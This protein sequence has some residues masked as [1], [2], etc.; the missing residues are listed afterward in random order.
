MTAPARRTVI[1]VTSH[2]PFV[3]RFGPFVAS[4][5]RRSR[6][7]AINCPVMNKQA[8]FTLPELIVTIVVLAILASLAAPAFKNFIANERIVA[9]ANELISSF[10]LARTEALKRNMRVTICKSSNPTAAT[11][12]CDTS[13]N[14][15]DGYIIFADGNPNAN[16]AIVAN[17]VFEPGAPNNEVLIKAQSALNDGNVNLTLRP[18]AGDTSIQNYVSYIPRGHTRLTVTDGS[19]AQSGVFKLCDDRGLSQVRTLTLS[20]TGR[21]RVQS[22]SAAQTSAGSC[23]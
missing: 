5:V 6:H 9:E 21:V 2:V 8:G 3:G 17:A 18:R 19:G 4:A 15:E 16:P 7:G 14:W 12:A 11:P 23:P 10:Y 20:L 1:A 13:A 22:G